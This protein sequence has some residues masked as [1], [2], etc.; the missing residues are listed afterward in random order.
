MQHAKF[1]IRVQH[2]CKCNLTNPVLKK[3]AI[4]KQF[5][6]YAFSELFVWYEVFLLSML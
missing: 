4:L 3:L 6:R 2:K 1:K 5:N